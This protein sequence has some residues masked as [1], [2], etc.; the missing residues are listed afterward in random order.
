VTTGLVFDIKK[1]ALHDGPGLRTTVFFKGCP[2]ECWLCHNPESRDVRPE[3]MVRTAGTVLCEHCLE[4]FHEGAFSQR[5][6]SRAVLTT[7]SEV[8]E[9]C[10]ALFLT[11]EVAI[12]GRQMTSGEVLE[13]IERD[14]VF[15]EE[16]G[17]GV[18]FSGGEPLLQ[19]AFLEELLDG[20]SERG[21]QTA[22]DTSG[23]APL[24]ALERIRDRTSLF[25]YDLKLM[26]EERHRAFT[27]VSNTP[28]LENLTALA[29]AGAD[30]IVRMPLLP[31]INDDD[32]NLKAA[33]AFLTSL[34]RRYPVDILPFHRIGIDKYARLG[35]EHPMPD[36]QPPGADAIGHAAGIL[37]DAG[38]DVMIREIG[39][40]HQ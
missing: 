40:E 14:A 24:E 18:T 7:G 3:L 19:I 8:C 9:A 20:C 1:F 15:Y 32:A 21:F 26:D 11:G 2:L 33:G 29:A 35:M 28:I 23:Y 22:V 38:L 27:G 37:S 5:P 36:L 31:G 10:T 6:G 30:V 13:E 25:L 12:A 17:G 34:D 16:S 39:Y 4:A